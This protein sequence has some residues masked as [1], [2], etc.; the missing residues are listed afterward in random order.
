MRPDRLG[1]MPAPIRVFIHRIRYKRDREYIIYYSTNEKETV[2][3]AQRTS[4]TGNHLSSPQQGSYVLIRLS[5]SNPMMSWGSLTSMYGIIM[6]RGIGVSV[7][8]V[9][10]HGLHGILDQGFVNVQLLPP[11]RRLCQYLPE[12]PPIVL[13]LC[14]ILPPNFQLEFTPEPL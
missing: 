7:V 6:S 14:L 9:R 13:F 3:E 12:I 2:R 11:S 4:K 1:F 10:N 8:V 5:V